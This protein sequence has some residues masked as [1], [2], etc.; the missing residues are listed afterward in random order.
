[1][2]IGRL[3]YKNLRDANEEINVKKRGG[4]VLSPP[5]TYLDFRIQDDTEQL[6]VR[7]NRFQ[8]EKM[9]KDLFNEVPIGAVLLIRAKLIPGY[10]FGWVNKWRR[11]DAQ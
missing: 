1:M 9:G 10:R 4:K 2:F 11:I 3:I 7:I 6:L 5:T 8:Y